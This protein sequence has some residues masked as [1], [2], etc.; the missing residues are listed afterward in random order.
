MK[1]EIGNKALFAFIGLLL[2]VGSLL[3]IT[4]TPSKIV[5]ATMCPA[6]TG[7]TADA[8]KVVSAIDPTQWSEEQMENVIYLT[9]RDAANACQAEFD[10]E[11]AT[12]TTHLQDEKNK[13]QAVQGCTYAQTQGPLATCDI[14]T[15]CIVNDYTRH[16]RC[17]WSWDPNQNKMVKDQSTCGPPLYDVNMVTCGSSNSFTWENSC[18]SGPGGGG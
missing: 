9:A 11:V 8:S 18:H 2:V 17:L 10:S 15:S 3:T 16:E 12:C 6:V 5:E 7:C 14:G 1:I 4:V 13:C